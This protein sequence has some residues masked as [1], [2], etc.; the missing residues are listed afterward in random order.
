MGAQRALI[1]RRQLIELGAWVAL[2]AVYGCRKRDQASVLSGLVTEVVLGVAREMRAESKTLQ[3]E[4]RALSGAPSLERARAAQAA[5]KRALVAWKMAYAFRS[6]PF[7][8]SEAFQRAAF[9]PVRPTLI[10]GALAD[11]EPIDERRVEQ[12]A[13]DARGL[14]ALEY[15]LFDE[16]NAG[17]LGLSSDARGERARAYALELGANILGYAERIQRLLGNGQ[18]Y[19]ASFAN[20]GKLS[21]DTLVSQTLDTLTVV[22]GKFA[23]VERARR[24]NRPLP[25]AVEG[26]YSKSSLD[27]VLAIIAG[28]KSLYLGGGSGGLSD[29]VASSSKPIDDHVRASFAE[30]EQYLRSIGMPIE[31]A[32][33]AQPT[34]FKAGAAAVAELRH[35]IEVELVSALS[36]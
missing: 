15:L 24:E 12:L 8:S 26:Y 35:V 7:V 14:Y 27:I 9:W 34:L 32:L 30:T 36:S 3:A 33:E 6:G 21:V 22:S 23:R 11:H 18:A 13:V 19:A 2:P 16:G 17:T 29:L 10:N 20:G 1:T 28:T 5:F 25:F 4:L 31:V